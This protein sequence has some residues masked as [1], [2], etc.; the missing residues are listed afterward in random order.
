MAIA[1]AKQKSSL[2]PG[3]LTPL[4]RATLAFALLS[5]GL[6]LIFKDAALSMGSI[7]FG[8]S[9]YH[10]GAIV[11]PISLWLVL[12]DLSW[13]DSAPVAA[14]RGGAI[15]AVATA[16]WL[17]SRA[18]GVALIGHAALTTAVIGAVIAIYGTSLAR[19]WGFA[20]AFLYFMVPFG[21]ELTPALQHLSA[22]AVAGM[23][24]FAGVETARDGYVLATAVSRF[25]MAPSCAGLRFL[26]ASAMLS[27]LVSHL[28]FRGWRKCTAFIAA[29]LVAA[30]LANWLR[31]FLIVSLATATDLRL[32]VGPEHVALGWVLYAAMI[33][34]L[35][36]LARHCADRPIGS[37]PSGTQ[38][39]GSPE[40]DA[41]SSSQP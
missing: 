33:A 12:R 23:L 35:I 30:V 25:E 8:S 15:I 26:L 19:R 4:I 10:H 31:A 20:L 37:S 11:A 28:A 41:R 9:V 21:E 16:F 38:R 40:S 24:N 13:R 14:W 18:S 6:V 2:T 17:I 39:P 5:A 34:G 1:F 22:S 32:G 27:A 29:A 36:L 7:W 3:A